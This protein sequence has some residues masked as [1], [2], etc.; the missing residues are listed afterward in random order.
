[1]KKSMCLWLG[2]G[3]LFLACQHRSLRGFV[4]GV[5]V[6]HSEG[7]FSLSDDTLVIRLK[8]RDQFSV[9]RKTGFNRIREGM[10]GGREHETENWQVE[11]DEASAVLNELNHG[12]VIRLFPDSAML[13]IGKREYSK[14][15]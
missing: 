8:D 4:P 6:N 13:R 15:K 1:M 7:E 10:A 11:L 2:F 9:E 14:I 5:Y 12:K 3:M